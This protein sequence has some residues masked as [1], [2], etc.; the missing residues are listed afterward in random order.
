MA[1]PAQ[2]TFK[3]KI[4]HKMGLIA[5]LGLIGMLALGG[6]GYLSTSKID[7]TAV[8]A[9]DR[10]DDIRNNLVSSYDQ[11]LNSESI[12]RELGNLN[13]RLIELMD[14]VISGPNRGVSE[15]QILAE[16]Q[17]LVQEA[18]LIYKVPGSER[19]IE[20][21]K[22]SIGKVTVNN[23][24]DVATLLEFELPDLY[25]LKGNRSKFRARQG[26][27]ALS[28]AKMYYFISKNLQELAGNSL[29]EVKVAKQTLDQALQSADA[30]M[31]KTRQNLH[32]SSNQAAISLIIVFVLTLTV[33]GI[34]FGLFAR[35]ITK[36]LQ[37]TVE[38]TRSLREGRVSARLNLGQRGDEFGSMARGLNDFADTLEHEVVDAMQKLAA[39][40]FNI[41]IHPKDQ[42]DLVRT[43]LKQT[44]DKLSEVMAEILNGSY[45]ISSGSQQVSDSAQTLS[46]GASSSAASLEEISA[47]MNEMSGQI[48]LSADNAD[49]AN[50]LSTEAKVTAESGNQKMQQM[51][52]AMIEI[53]DSGQGISKIIKAID[54]IAFQTNLLALN[55]AVEAARAGQHGKG[56]A[57]VAEEVRNLAARSAKAASETTD[58]IQESVTK[59]ENGVQIADETANALAEIVNGITKV[60]DLVEEIATASKEQAHGIAQANLGLTQIDQVIQ[61]NTATSE[62]SAATSEELSAQAQRLQQLLSHFQLQQKDLAPTEQGNYNNNPHAKTIGWNN[63]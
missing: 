52:T 12:A 21:T 14:M 7:S 61:T 3:L 31:A 8:Q 39:G 59:T 46:D 43:A 10:N 30:E 18:E 62:E 5:L 25:S 13:R 38:M 42:Q 6:I 55:A 60:S 41:N 49:Q 16:A 27:I 47:S 24:V 22:N 50:Q 26:D 48:Q 37:A 54:E 19:I 63:S 32:A 2:S 56:F 33:V 58:L 4:F 44:A 36:P 1:Q 45:Q 23:F 11:A 40:D 53:R 34:V 9:L 15:Q 35:S 28:M 17:H 57:V 51:V 20:G 29:A